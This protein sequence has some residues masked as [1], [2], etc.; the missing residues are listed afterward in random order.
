MKTDDTLMKMSH[1]DANVR[2]D[3]ENFHMHY[4][5]CSDYFESE[6]EEATTLCARCER[7][8]YPFC[9][10]HVCRCAYCEEENAANQ[11]DPNEKT[12]DYVQRCFLCGC[13]FC[14]IIAITLSPVV[15]NKLDDDDATAAKTCRGCLFIG[16]LLS[17]YL[18]IKED[19]KAKI[20]E[21]YLQQ[22][23]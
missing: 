8:R 4:N 5:M 11:F 15:A 18:H 9:V 17:S 16:I 2:D 7:N 3:F 14:D 1:H 23:R 6:E 19:A 10:T 13:C 12:M 21:L 22:Q 20:I